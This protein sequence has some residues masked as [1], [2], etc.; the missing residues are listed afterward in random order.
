MKFLPNSTV[1]DNSTLA[2]TA[3]IQHDDKETVSQAITEQDGQWLLT[4]DSVP[5]DAPISIHFDIMVKTLDGDTINPIIPPIT[6]DESLFPKDIPLDQTEMPSEIEEPQVPDQDVQVK[7]EENDINWGWTV[8]I[9]VLANI[10]LG[11]IA[12]FAVKMLK[13]AA[14]KKQQQLMGRLE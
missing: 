3:H 14:A 1:L 4:I 5:D 8:A 10:L 12:I 13:S 9:V 7:T 2:I 6:I 11:G